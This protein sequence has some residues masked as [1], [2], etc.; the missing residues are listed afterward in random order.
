MA[1]QLR[2]YLE[3]YDSEFERSQQQVKD[4]VAA[5]NE[6]AKADRAD[7]IKSFEDLVAE[8]VLKVLQEYWV[9]DSEMHVLDALQRPVTCRF[10]KTIVPAR[11]A[12]NEHAD[13]G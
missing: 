12:D 10:C 9:L 7:F 13:K 4:L 5:N 8:K 6:K 3:K 1:E 2:P 11:G